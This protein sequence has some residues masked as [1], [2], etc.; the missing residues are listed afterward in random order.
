MRTNR[1]EYAQH[2]DRAD[3]PAVTLL[4]YGKPVKVASGLPT[5]FATKHAESWRAARHA[6]AKR[7]GARALRTLADFF[8]GAL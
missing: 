6:A 3:Q 4:H 2:A 7:P 8:G 5:D 1:N